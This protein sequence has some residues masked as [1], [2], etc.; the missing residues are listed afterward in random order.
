MDSA[1]KVLDNE[2]E[3]D[4]EGRRIAVVVDAEMLS[5]INSQTSIG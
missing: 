1:S 5:A 2:D 3:G 4:E